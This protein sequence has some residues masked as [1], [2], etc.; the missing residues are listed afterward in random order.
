[1]WF[2]S[3]KISQFL[4]IWTKNKAK[5]L[6]VYSFTYVPV[7]L[8]PS[9]SVPLL[10]LP[11]L[12]IYSS[13]H[14]YL[15]FIWILSSILPEITLAKLNSLLLDPVGIFCFFYLISHFFAALY[16]CSL[17]CYN[18]YLLC[19]SPPVSF[20]GSFNFAYPL[21]TSVLHGSLGLLLF[22]L[23]DTLSWVI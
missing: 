16:I 20:M 8:S 6:I 23:S 9:F 2:Q 15:T 19:V 1:M 17:P 22:S 18:S 11:F 3:I 5:L 14:A 4:S 21:N 10:L 7:F 13:L 12:P